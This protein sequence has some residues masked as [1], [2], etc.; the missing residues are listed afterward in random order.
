MPILIVTTVSFLIATVS[1][2]CVQ[3]V[4]LLYGV[5]GPLLKFGNLSGSIRQCR[6]RGSVLLY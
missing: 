6:K 4:R 5:R 1:K 3:L 2:V